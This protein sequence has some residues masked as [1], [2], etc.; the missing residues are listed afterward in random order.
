MKR[1]GLVDLHM[2]GYGGYDTRTTDPE[3]ILQMAGD[4]KKEGTSA[5]L[6]TIYPA[7]LEE[8]RRNIEA[9]KKAM[10]LQRK[11]CPV[12]DIESK[13]ERGTRTPALILGVNLEGPFLNP[14][15]RGALDASSFL[16][17]TVSSLKKLTEGYEDIVKIMTIAPEMPGALRVIERCSEMGIIVNMG[18]SDATF[19]E[20]TEGKRAGATGV[21]HIFNAMRPFHHREPGLAGFGLLDEDVFIEVIADGVHLHPLTLKLIFAVKR[22]DRIIIVSDSVKGAGR[23]GKPA[24]ASRGILA[25]GGIPLARSVSMLGKIGIA[26][27]D[28]LE[29]G[30][31]NPLMLLTKK[32]FSCMIGLPLKPPLQ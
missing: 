30:F 14:R 11:E 25:G 23:D 29:T 13:A 18:H 21:T 32:K 28:A 5:I 2:H 20:A 12:Q 24:Y 15:R 10:M 19:L 8:M 1:R 31:R 16:R 17:P 4:L 3:D 26:A 9:V 7:F 22:L 6:P 27:E